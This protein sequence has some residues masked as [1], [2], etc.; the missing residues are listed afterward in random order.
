MAATNEYFNVYL[1][2]FLQL[3]QFLYLANEMFRVLF[4]DLFSDAVKFYQ[5]N[6]KFVW[7]SPIL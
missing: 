3:V 6:I 2:F 1:L 5:Q 7:T 4:Q